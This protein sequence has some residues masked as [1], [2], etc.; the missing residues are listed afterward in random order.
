MQKQIT[1]QKRTKAHTLNYIFFVCKNFEKLKI[2]W[3]R[4]VADYIFYV[5]DKWNAENYGCE[6]I[7][8]RDL[9]ITKE[10]MQKLR[11]AKFKRV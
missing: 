1:Y 7:E 3:D 11:I 5:A 9:P 10:T 4:S 2:K 6:E 8:P